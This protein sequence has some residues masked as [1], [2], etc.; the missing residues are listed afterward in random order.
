L[1]KKLFGYIY[2]GTFLIIC[3]AFVY[4]VIPS[5]NSFASKYQYFLSMLNKTRYT[6][7]VFKGTLIFALTAAVLLAVKKTFIKHG[8]TVN[9]L[10]YLF[11]NLTGVVF[12]VFHMLYNLER[13][14]LPP[15]AYTAQ[16]IANPSSAFFDHT[17]LAFFIFTV[18]AV[19]ALIYTADIFIPDRKRKKNQPLDKQNC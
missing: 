18:P 10:F 19:L 14:G 4:I 2:F 12:T 9:I 16:T 17:F 8:R 3:T 6:A 5:D 13:V 15:E 1:K 11:G 7:L